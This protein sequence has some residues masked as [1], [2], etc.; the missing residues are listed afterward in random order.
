MGGG[1]GV[2]WRHSKW[3]LMT[4]LICLKSGVL[5]IKH[6]VLSYISRHTPYN[7][8]FKIRGRPRQRERQKRKRRLKHKTTTLHVH[9][10]FLSWKC[11]IPRSMVDV[12][13]PRRNFPSPSDLEYGYWEFNSGELAYIWQRKWVEL[14]AMKT[15]RTSI[16]FLSNVFAPAVILGS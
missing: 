16:H 6:F 7:M 2:R 14:I 11:L 5:K 4:V 1:G 3:L 13:K 15:E 8:D 9:H 10:T 12:N